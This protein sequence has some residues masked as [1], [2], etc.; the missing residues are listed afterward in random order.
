MRLANKTAIITGVGAGIGQAIAI[1]FAE[2]GARLVLNDISQPAAQATLRKVTDLGAQAV[3]A[4]ADISQEAGARSISD[5]AIKQFGSIDILVNNAADFTQK[6]VEHAEVTDWQKVLGVN[7][8]GTALVS[9]HAIPHMKARGGSIVNIASM[10]AIIAQPD[11]A[12]YNSSKGAMLTMA[13]C[14]ALDLAPYKI[15][16]NSICPGCILT[17]ASYR[18]IERMGLTFEQWRDRAA[19]LHMLNRLGE[20]RE[21]ANAA[22]F[23]ASDESSFI[24]ATHL[25]VDGGYTGR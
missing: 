1:R 25:M 16:V 11:F 15:R 19:P 6:S 22:L 10:S 12:T 4:V 20:P 8:I 2:E 23:L 3:L 17:S 9:K 18:E 24:T 7:V 14:M 5:V 13:K 21:V